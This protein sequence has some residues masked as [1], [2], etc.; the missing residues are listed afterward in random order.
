MSQSWI[1]TQFDLKSS[2]LNHLSKLLRKGKESHSIVSNSLRPYGLYSP[3]NSPDQNTRVGSCFLVQGI[4]PT[5]RSNPGLL[6]CMRILYQL[7]HQGSPKERIDTGNRNAILACRW[8]MKLIWSC[9]LKEKER[10]S[11][12]LQ[13]PCFSH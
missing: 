13:S 4:F 12:D 11:T 8:L 2:F 3:W 10:R 1:L 6:H 7:S 5:E 9:I